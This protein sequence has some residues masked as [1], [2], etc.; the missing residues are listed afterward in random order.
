[1]KDALVAPPIPYGLSAAHRGF[2]GVA[3]VKVPTFISLIE[4]LIFSLAEFG[5]RQI[6]FVNGHYTN[7]PAINLACLNASHH[8]PE[9]VH[10][11]ALSYWDA[12]PPAQAEDYLSLK[13]GLHANI[14]ETSAVMAA[15]PGLVRLDQ[16]VEGWPNFPALKGPSMPVVF[17]YFETA[18]GS[19]FKSLSYGVWGNPTGSSAELGERFYQEITAAVCAVIDDVESSFAQIDIEQPANHYV[20]AASKT[21]ESGSRPE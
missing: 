1:M 6:L 18:A 13:A 12:L 2:K 16:A 11:W 21:E 15:A 19:C 8:L 10:P 20:R 14:G 17:A 5:F 9:N 7:Y 3:Y 4:D